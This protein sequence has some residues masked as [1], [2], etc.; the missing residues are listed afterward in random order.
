MKAKKRINYIA[1][2]RCVPSK[3]VKK[4]FEAAAIRKALNS[5]LPC[6]R[7]TATIILNIKT[8]NGP[9]RTFVYH[10]VYFFSLI[11]QAF[12]FCVYSVLLAFIERSNIHISVTLQCSF[13]LLYRRFCTNH[14]TFYSAMFHSTVCVYGEH[15]ISI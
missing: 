12:H 8:T 5:Y 6:R 15:S 14:R 11:S 3:I 1:Y 10:I 2:H 13:Y 7:L 4:S 9:L